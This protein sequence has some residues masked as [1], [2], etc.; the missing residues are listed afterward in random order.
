MPKPETKMKNPIKPL[1]RA[2]LLHVSVQESLRAYIEDNGLQ[3]GA[4]LPPE[5]GLPPGSVLAAIPCA[6]RSR[7]WNR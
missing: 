1:K 7:R 6:R 3:A 4:P 2:P 5:G